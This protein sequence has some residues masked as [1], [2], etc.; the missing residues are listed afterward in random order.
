MRSLLLIVACLTTSPSFAAVAWKCTYNGETFF[1]G[2][3]CEEAIKRGLTPPFKERADSPECADLK[4]Q[5]HVLQAALADA[6]SPPGKVPDEE[7][8]RLD[9]SIAHLGTEQ[10]LHGCKDVPAV[11]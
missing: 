9:P 11:P 7:V 1:V 4:R 6:V 10:R 5:K 2:M 8:A 3:P